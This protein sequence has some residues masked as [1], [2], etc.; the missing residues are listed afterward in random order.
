MIKIASFLWFKSKNIFI[1]LT[2]CRFTLCRAFD[3][4]SFDPL[5]FDPLSFDPVSFDPLSFDPVSFDP[6]SFD[7]MSFDP[8]SFDPMSVNLFHYQS[9]RNISNW[10]IPIQGLYTKK[11]LRWFE[12]DFGNCCNI[13]LYFYFIY[14]SRIRCNPWNFIFLKEFPTQET[15]TKKICKLN[16]WA[17]ICFNLLYFRAKTLKRYQEFVCRISK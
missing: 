1:I 16:E 9:L 3:P 15:S 4:L 12:V 7:P 10:C 6:M 8:V 11:R 5:S 14:F 17:F 13:L 2:F